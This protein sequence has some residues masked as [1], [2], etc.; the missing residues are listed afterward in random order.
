LKLQ[1]D[2]A[3]AAAGDLDITD[4]LTIDGDPAGGTIINAKAARTARSRCSM[5]PS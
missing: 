1:G 4:T 3:I 5:V 2:D